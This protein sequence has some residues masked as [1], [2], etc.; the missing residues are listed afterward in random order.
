MKVSCGGSYLLLLLL[1]VH[2]CALEFDLLDEYK[3]YLVDFKKDSFR[4]KD[5]RRRQQFQNNFRKVMEHTEMSK[6]V[7]SAAMFKIKLNHFADLLPAELNML[8]PAETSIG[9]EMKVQYRICVPLV[10]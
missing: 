8:F 7:P 6:S 2:S 4:A 1:V 10:R 3:N 5:E 9:N